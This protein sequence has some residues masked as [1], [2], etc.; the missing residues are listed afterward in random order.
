MIDDLGENGEIRPIQ[1]AL[2][3]FPYADG[4]IPRVAGSSTSAAAAESIVPTVGTKQAT[5]LEIL[6]AHPRGLTDDDLEQITG[7][8]HQTVSARRR[9]LV[10][11]GWVHESGT[12]RRTSS[13]RYATVWQAS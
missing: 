7:W 8:R 10:L 13:G 4:Q 12:E 1:L 6:R 3:A 11:A 5:V 9:E 2:P